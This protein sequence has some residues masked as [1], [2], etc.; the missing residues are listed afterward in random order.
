MLSARFRRLFH[1]Q[2]LYQRLPVAHHI[3]AAGDAA[4]LYRRRLGALAKAIGF[5]VGAQVIWICSITLIGVSLGLS[6]HLKWYNYFTYIPLIYIIG[7]LPLTPGGVGVVEGLYIRFFCVGGAGAVAAGVTPSEILAL[8]M[9]A[10]FIPILWGLPGIVVA[11][12]G[13]KLPKAEQMQA[14]LEAGAKS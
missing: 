12:T 2:K 1:L 4:Q 6:A 14:E 10:R 8:A 3:A 7:A 13:P 9:F 5:T 11:I